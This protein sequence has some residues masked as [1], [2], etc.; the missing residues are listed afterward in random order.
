MSCLP[1]AMYRESPLEHTIDP[2]YLRELGPWIY[3]AVQ[4]G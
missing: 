2:R 4:A 3:E 1:H